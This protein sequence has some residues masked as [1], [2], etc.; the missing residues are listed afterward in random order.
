[1]KRPLKLHLGGVINEG[2]LWINGEYAGSRDE[3]RLALNKNLFSEH[4]AGRALG[5]VADEYD[6]VL[7]AACDIFHV[8]DRGSA[9]EHARW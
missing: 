2:W 8:E 9:L 6:S 5:L 7:A 1:V 3:A 4:S